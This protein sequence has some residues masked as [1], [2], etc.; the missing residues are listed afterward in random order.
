MTKVILNPIGIY[1]CYVFIKQ[2]KVLHTHMPKKKKKNKKKFLKKQS[3]D[4]E[5]Q[6]IF[7]GLRE[8]HFLQMAISESISAADTSKRIFS[9]K[10]GKYCNGRQ[11]ASLPQQSCLWQL[12]LV[13]CFNP[14][15]ERR[16]AQ[17]RGCT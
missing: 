11:G 15:S 16:E 17:K 5:P 7:H 3:E 9:K 6:Q 2:N 1:Q 12:H 4:K 14:S 10:P 13:L 8:G